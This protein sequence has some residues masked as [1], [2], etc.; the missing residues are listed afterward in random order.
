MKTTL[1]IFGIVIVVI[2]A[3]AIIVPMALKPKIGEIVK[4]EA[5]AMLNA[6]LDFDDLDISLL[7]HFPHAS[8]E[9][10][11]LA[12]TGVDRFEGD[13][14]V[15]ADRV[16]V[17]VN[18]M[19][20]FGDSGYEVTK[21]LLNRP[22][23]HAHKLADGAVNWDVMKT[24]DEEPQPAEEAPAEE[25]SASSKEPS[26]FKLQVRDLRINDGRLSYEDDST[27]MSFA[28]APMDLRLRGDMSADQ[29]DLDLRL[30]LSG[31]NLT[32]GGVKLL[33]NA[34]LELKGVIAA[35][36]ANGRYTLSN[37][38]LRLNTIELGIDG[39]VE[40][41]AEAVGMDIAVNSSKVRFKDL[42]SMIPA[43]YTKDF[44]NLTASGTLT[45]GAW[46]K[47]ELKG[48]MLPAFGVDLK[49]ADGSF[50]Y[51]ALPESVSGINLDLAV[52]NEGGTMDKT[53][54]D[55]RKFTMTMAGNTLQATAHVSTPVSDL[56]FKVAAD[57]RVDLGAI[58][59]VYP[60]DESTSLAG[61][62]TLDV[63][64]EGRMSDIEKQRYE[65]MKAS[66]SIA[67]EQMT[68]RM[69]GL[70]DVQIGRIAANISPAAMNLDECSVTV[71]SSD[72]SAK[73][74]L[75]NYI[76]YLLRG[77]TLHGSLDVTS[78]LLDVNELMALMPADETTGADAVADAEIEDTTETAAEPVSAIEVPKNL[79]L[80]LSVAMNRILFQKMT[81]DNFS[82]RMSVKNGTL[83]LDRLALG[84]FGGK[85]S[86]SGSYSTAADPSS[87]ALKL[88]L[89]V[90]GARFDETFKQLDL[91]Q[92]MVPIFEKVGG[93][94]S[95]DMSLSTSLKSD[96][97]VDYDSLNASGLIS[98]GH[99]DV[100]NVGAID[101]LAEVLGNDKLR[102]ITA[103]DVKISFTI[104]DG[105]VNTSPFDI[106]MG[107]INMTL[108]G[109]TGLD[110]SIDY[111]AR[112][113]LPDKVGGGVVSDV[114][115]VIGGTF[116][117]PTVTVDVEDVARQAVTNI[118]NDQV[119][120]L[121]GSENL[122]DE[123]EKQ[124]AKLREEAEKAGD[125][126][127]EE[128]RKQRQNLIDKASG[129]IARLAAEKSGD[130]LVKAA[131]KQAANLKAEAE[132]QISKL[133]AE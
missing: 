85:M 75:S 26:S 78:K 20:I 131:E 116:T 30:L 82:G 95:M 111:R 123:I 100:A 73:G 101:K 6:R 5:N 60:L 62:V 83:S 63:S 72:L 92:K 108:S 59:R 14:I 122:Q 77:D 113:A 106:S 12:L 74:K 103:K 31:M 57:G 121:T 22:A 69:K 89:D 25:E 24:T 35:D 21:V 115:A 127:V 117:A 109:S 64:A 71:G 80:S 11:G 18:L 43:F 17:V 8:L 128:A 87:P 32:N 39:W 38:M 49:V 55:V 58:G 61:I 36:L 53:V 126:L 114:T 16:S 110:Q 98:T 37:S 42:L 125:K 67:V 2:L 13:T 7:R 65:S 81:I 27:N 50:K 33:N 23:V 84:A 129:P 76:G 88:S 52:G 47:G 119:Q 54:V 66:G 28:V 99:L 56:R 40:T 93:D 68:A 70:P 9:L 86:A 97:T 120:K 51:D 46:A 94:Y 45:L 133:T 10:K 29:T 96:M 34:E 107:D 3:V 19:S 44:K 118:V 15:A 1:K 91:V 132:K 104:R 4:R 130:A 48:D 105:R 112:V 41:G 124:A 79:D 102:N 90:A